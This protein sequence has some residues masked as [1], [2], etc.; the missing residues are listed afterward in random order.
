MGAVLHEV[1]ALPRLRRAPGV[2]GTLKRF[3]YNINGTEY[4]QYLDA[5]MDP[6]PWAT[7]FI[8]QVRFRFL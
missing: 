3:P 2:S 1:F 7:T 8:L 5:N 4:Y 6:T